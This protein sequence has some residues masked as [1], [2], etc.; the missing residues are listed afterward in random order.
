M[1]RRFGRRRF[2]GDSQSETASFRKAKLAF[3]LMSPSARGSEDRNP[4]CFPMLL[5]D[6]VVRNGLYD[7]L[8][9]LYDVVLLDDE[10]RRFSAYV[11]VLGESKQDAFQAPRSRHVVSEHSQRT[12]KYGDQGR[13]ISQSR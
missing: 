2:S 13:V 4:P 8:D 7:V 5:D 11:L 1:F 3:R 12:R 9:L 6:H 10:S